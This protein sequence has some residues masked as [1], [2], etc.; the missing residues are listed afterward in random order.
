MK[1]VAVAG[2]SLAGLSAARALRT[3]GYDG[4]LVIVGDEP[5]RPYDRPPLSRRRPDPPV[6]RPRRQLA[7]EAAQRVGSR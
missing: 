3:Q 5:H 4:R 6:L 1:S 2:A 7:T